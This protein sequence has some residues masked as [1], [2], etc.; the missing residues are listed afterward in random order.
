MS[1]YVTLIR[2]LSEELSL[3]GA[4]QALVTANR[5]VVERMEG[6]I[7]AAVGRGGRVIEI[8]NALCIFSEPKEENAMSEEAEREKISADYLKT[9]EEVKRQY[10]QYVEVSELYAL[11]TRKETAA[12]H[13]QPPSLEHPLTTNTIRITTQKG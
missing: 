3:I 6:E 11:P 8:F 13:H 7:R 12:I 9:L 10:Q 1:D 4:T 2:L 5:A